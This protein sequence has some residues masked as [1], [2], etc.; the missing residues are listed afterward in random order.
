VTPD[1]HPTALVD[2]SASLADD[3][4][5]GPFSVIGP[6]ATLGPGVEVGHRVTLEGRVVLGPGVK[7]GHGA[8]VGGAPQDLKFKPG[9]PS[10]VRV[11][12]GT[13]IREYVTIHRATQPEGWTEVGEDCLIMA[14]S[15]IAH[16]CRVGRK[17]III[18]YAGITGHCQIGDF[19]TIGGYAGILPFVRVGAY[20]YMGA[21]GKIIADLPPGMLADGNPAT[22]RGVNAVG[23]RRAG[24]PASERRA[25]EDA[26][27]LLYRRGLSPH[28]ALERLRHEVPATPL[29]QQLIEFVASSRK[30][31]CAPPAGWRGSAAPGEADAD[32]ERERVV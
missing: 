29:L 24:V 1:I 15:H 19:A 13:V 21:C 2:S 30:G 26:H 32:A 18:N 25:L 4:R 14:Y 7:I 3:V 6:E 9:T 22:V 31:I 12:G 17:V 8:V 23:L 16:D 10:G 5:V 11:G 20:A 27:R 28:S